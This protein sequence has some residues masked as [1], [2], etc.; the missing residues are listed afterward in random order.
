MTEGKS[1]RIMRAKTQLF[2]YLTYELVHHMVLHYGNIIPF[3]RLPAPKNIPGSTRSDISDCVAFSPAASRRRRQMPKRSI[4]EALSL[5]HLAAAVDFANF[6]CQKRYRPFLGG[7][8][9]SLSPTKMPPRGSTSK[10]NR[11]SW[12]GFR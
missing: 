3:S 8:S 9:L 12:T 5:S 6:I 10:R 2:V 11:D 4:R 7:P 1:S